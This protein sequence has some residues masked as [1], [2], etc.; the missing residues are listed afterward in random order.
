MT[1]HEDFS[2]ETMRRTKL[3]I[4]CHLCSHLFAG[5]ICFEHH[6]LERKPQGLVTKRTNSNRFRPL[7]SQDKNPSFLC[8]WLD[9][10]K[11]KL[12]KRFARSK[13]GTFL[14]L[15]F[16]A[17]CWARMTFLLIA[18]H[19]TMRTIKSTC[20]YPPLDCVALRLIVDFV[21]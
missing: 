14:S 6:R 11:C 4:Q 1:S 20:K 17:I 13:P 8:K 2:E 7:L 21:A 16:R 12:Q 18:R 3:V 5:N 19:I 10:N 15:R 9:C